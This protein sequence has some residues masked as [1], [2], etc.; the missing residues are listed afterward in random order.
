MESMLQK[1]KLGHN[2]FRHWHFL[3]VDILREYK[4]ADYHEIYG[5]NR[6]EFSNATNRWMFGG[7]L[8]FLNGGSAP[9]TR[10]PVPVPPHELKRYRQTSAQQCAN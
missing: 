9:H 2:R 10:F 7:G 4:W 5:S 3:T 1:R 6:L 8:D